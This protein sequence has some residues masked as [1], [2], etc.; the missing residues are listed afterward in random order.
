MV[1]WGPD[2]DAVFLMG[3]LEAQN[4]DM[5]QPLL[6]H[7]VNPIGDG[8]YPT[9]TSLTHPDEESRLFAPPYPRLHHKRLRLRLTNL[10]HRLYSQGRLSPI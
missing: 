3:I 9:V 4:M 10:V 8:K 5:C 2:K 1:I 7:L 6:Q